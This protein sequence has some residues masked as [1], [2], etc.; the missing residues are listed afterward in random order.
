MLEDK[1]NDTQNEWKKREQHAKD[2]KPRVEI[3]IHSLHGFVYKFD[4]AK[5]YDTLQK[6]GHT[7]LIYEKCKCRL[8]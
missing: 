5:C 1:M 2:C 7:S 3:G 8:G 4:G 6:L